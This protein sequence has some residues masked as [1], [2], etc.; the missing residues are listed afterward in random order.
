VFTAAS[1]TVQAA[2]SAASATSLTVTLPAGAIT[3]PVLVQSG[4]QSSGSQILEV[5]ASA[6]TLLP[7]T[8]VTVSGAATTSGVDIYVP[9]SAATLNLLQIGVGD[10]GTSISFGSSSVE[11][12]RGQT[13][14]LLIVGNGLSLSAGSTVTIA[15]GGVTLSGTS[16]QTAVVNSVPR[17]LV[18][19]NVAVDANATLGARN[20]VVTNSNLDRSVLSGG[21]FIR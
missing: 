19:I 14:Q 3:G 7:G 5:T 2:P 4:G 15:G 10:P 8:S 6:T 13:K 16:F 1:G 20:I 9:Q 11:V 21:L 18:F 12:S 17:D